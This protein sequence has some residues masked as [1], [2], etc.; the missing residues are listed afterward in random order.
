MPPLR[1]S[2]PI[3]VPAG[4]DTRYSNVEVTFMP[5]DGEV[6]PVGFAEA[7][8]GFVGGATFI[9][10]SV[11]GTK[12]I[13]CGGLLP[14]TVLSKSSFVASP[15][16]VSMTGNVFSFWLGRL[17]SSIL[18]HVAG[19]IVR[20]ALIEARAALC[21]GDETRLDKITVHEVEVH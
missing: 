1:R 16:S 3:P 6:I 8:L 15:H 2:D 14:G 5:R 9:G 11:P 4:A 18:K 13:R 10:S 21:L 20:L 19:E 17:D 12:M 7:I